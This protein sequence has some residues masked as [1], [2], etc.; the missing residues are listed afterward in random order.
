MRKNACIERC[1]IYIYIYVKAG[2]AQVSR[3]CCVLLQ[4]ERARSPRR[5]GEG[6]FVIFR[7]LL[8]EFWS[9]G[10]FRTIPILPRAASD[11]ALFHR[12]YACFFHRC[13]PPWTSMSGHQRREVLEAFMMRKFSL[14]PSGAVTVPPPGAETRAISESKWQGFVM[15]DDQCVGSSQKVM[16]GYDAWV[17]E[18]RVRAP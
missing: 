17:A 1:I 10:L 2:L 4:M 12:R 6:T 18:D 8:E 14:D 7:L 11:P 16:D 5:G 9:E 15:N 3:R 13:Q